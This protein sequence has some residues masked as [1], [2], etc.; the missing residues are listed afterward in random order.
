MWAPWRIRYIEQATSGRKE[1]GCILCD[2]PAAQDDVGTLLL[3]RGRLNYVMMNRYPYNAGHLMVVPYRHLNSPELMTAAGRNEHFK[4]VSDSVAAL[5]K[6]Y[7]CDG[8]NIGMNLGRAAGAGIDQHMH[9]HIVPRWS[10]DTNFMPVL[11]D[12]KVVNEALQET[13]KT[14]KPYFARL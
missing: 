5:K 14:L 3:F 13:Y 11:A 10:G 6:V 1:E 12:I 8:F 7:R 4:I 9:T 2:H